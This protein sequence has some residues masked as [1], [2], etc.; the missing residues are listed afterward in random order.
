MITNDHI[1]VIFKFLPD[2]CDFLEISLSNTH[3]LRNDVNG[4][5][6]P[7]VLTDPFCLISRYNYGFDLRQIKSG[8]LLCSENGVVNINH[9]TPG[10]WPY[11]DLRVIDSKKS[12]KSAREMLE[13][14]WVDQFLLKCMP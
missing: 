5:L 11:R 1:V 6:H 8:N 13:C 9:N 4:P 2:R 7:Q 14:A 3:A 12:F 10:S